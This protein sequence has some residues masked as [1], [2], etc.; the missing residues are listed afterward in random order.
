MMRLLWLSAL[1]CNGNAHALLNY[2]GF[3]VWQKEF[4]WLYHP[5][6]PS[7][8]SF[9]EV[10]KGMAEGCDVLL[11]DGTLEE[12][13][14]K[15]RRPYM[16]LLEHYGK[17]AHHIVTVGTCATF[18]G[19]FAQGGKGRSGLHFRGDE[20]LDIFKNFWQK[21][22]SLPGCP[23]QPEVLAGTLS[24][25]KRK[26]DI[27]LDPLRRPKYYYA[28]TVHD[29]CIR[30]EYFEY[31]IDEHRFGR[32]EGCMFYDHGCQGTYTHGSC[33][34]ILWNGLGSKTRNGQPCMGCTEPDFPKENL[35]QT[36]KHMGIP[37][38]MPLGVPRR[39]YLS[40]AGIAKAFRIE[41]FYTPLMKEE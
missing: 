11:V 8:Y 38:R 1:A 37:A 28:Y 25:L 34:K 35:W 33:N 29:G 30:N 19:I 17:Q 9:K 22:I 41:R 36:P 26:T 32:L 31:K 20:R 14:V 23:V 18:G 3:K 27:P 21:S 16:E 12:G 6:L 39:A 40:L 24:L 2:P 13:Y 4:E 15:Y 5:L 10:E 7:E